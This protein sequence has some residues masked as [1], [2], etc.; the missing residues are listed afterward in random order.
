[1]GVKDINSDIM[2]GTILNL[3]REISGKASGIIHLNTDDSLKL[4]GIMKFNIKNGQI[5]K[6]G[7]IQYILNVASVFRNPL[8]MISPTT[9]LDMINIPEGNFDKISGELNIQNNIIKL[10]KIKSQSPQLSNYIV[11]YYDLEKS[12][13]ILRIYTKFSNKHKG[14]AGFLR[15]ISLNSLANQI[16]L[17]SKNDMN[18]YAAELEQLPPIDADEK[19]C[20]IFLTKIDGDIQNNNFLSSLKKIK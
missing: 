17:N 4:N 18:Y 10:L 9:I 6:I 7:L 11:G 19:N 13:A 12:D 15:N 5:Q 8:V 1:M 3:P 14:V 2:F 16:S 20:Q